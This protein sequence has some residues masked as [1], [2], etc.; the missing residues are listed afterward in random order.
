MSASSQVRE[1][2]RTTE[3]LKRLRCLLAK[4]FTN[5]VAFRNERQ[6]KQT[7]VL[8]ANTTRAMTALNND[9]TS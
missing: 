8:K 6:R 1:G 5:T 7:T 3:E 4:G 9:R 2:G